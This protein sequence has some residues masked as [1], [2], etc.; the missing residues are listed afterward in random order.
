MGE[1]IVFV[2][3]LQNILKTQ[4][5]KIVEVRSEYQEANKKVDKPE[6]PI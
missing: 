4:T 2:K 1:E 3:L 6:E 5:K